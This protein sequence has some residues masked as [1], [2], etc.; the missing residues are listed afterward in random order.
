MLKLLLFIQEYL[1][2]DGHC[3]MQD[4]NPKDYASDIFGISAPHTLPRIDHMTDCIAHHE[5][6][7][8]GIAIGCRLQCLLVKD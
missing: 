1:Y 5:K 2:P 3:L 7:L 4:N 8:I 6:F